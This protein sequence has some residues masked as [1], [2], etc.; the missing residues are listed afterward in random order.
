M[1]NYALLCES[2][3]VIIR[4]A[5]LKSRGL[6]P[7]QRSFMREAIRLKLEG[8]EDEIP[9]LKDRCAKAIRGHEWP[10]TEL[11]KTVTLQDSPSTYASKIEKKSR[12]RDA[13]YELALHA[14]RE[15]RAGD[16]MTFYVTG[17]KKNVPVYQY[18][19][20]VSEA[21]P[22]ARDENIAYY[23]AKLD[24]VGAK[25]YDASGSDEGQSEMDL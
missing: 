18:A 12:G 14:K 23:L 1:K 13:G 11:A 4:G 16:Q 6:E 7:F 3:D 22:A 2:G 25:L 8:R 9:G 21:D 19:K 20:L 5:A 10:L 15:Y 24:A 17:E